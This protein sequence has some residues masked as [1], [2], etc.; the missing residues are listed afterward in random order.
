LF[1]KNDNSEK[2]IEEVRAFEEYKDALVQLPLFEL[3]EEIADRFGFNTLGKERA[4]ISGFKEAVFDYVS[5]NKSDLG[6][7]LE[8]WELKKDTRTVK[9][10][11]SHDAVRIM[12]IHKS[13]GLQFKV[14]LLP[15]MDWDIVNSRGILWSTYEESE[16]SQLIVP[17][18]LTAALA[19]TS[20]ADHYRQEVMMAF[21]DSLNM[22][23]VALTRA[24]EVI[25]ALSEEHPSKGEGAL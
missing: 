13:K 18:S 24:E 21:L 25:W 9:V 14:V 1:E 6:G 15:F 17:L 7:F 10:P 23:Y 16:S 20:F 5:K 2:I 11:E 8:W 19:Q 3:V 4:Y 22:I 12:T